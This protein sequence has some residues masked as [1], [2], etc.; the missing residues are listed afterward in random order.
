MRTLK[1][2]IIGAGDIAPA[3]IRGCAPFAV[4][5]LVACA[6]ILPDKAQAFA[7]A[8]GIEALPVA[9]LLARDDIEIVINATPPTA[10]IAE[11]VHLP[12]VAPASVS[13]ASALRQSA[14]RIQTI[15]SAATAPA[16]GLSMR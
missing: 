5:D 10:Q 1:V 14:R 16:A 3:Y 2:G 15:S 7:H 4:I 9:D 8:H 12:R 11:F 6:D 13:P